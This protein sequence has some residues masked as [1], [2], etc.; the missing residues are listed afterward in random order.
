[1]DVSFYGGGNPPVALQR[2]GNILL[3]PITVAIDGVTWPLQLMFPA[4][5]LCIFTG[6]DGLLN[7][8][9]SPK[10]CSAL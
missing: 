1:M 9:R 3:L 4:H 6:Q 8:K 5:A 2:L 10:G 7:G